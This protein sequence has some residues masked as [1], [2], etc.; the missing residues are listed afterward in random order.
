MLSD[1][2]G[3]AIAFITII[4]L[5]SVLVTSMTQLTQAV[6]RLRARNLMK[7]V[8]AVIIKAQTKPDKE[9]TREE[10]KEAKIKPHRY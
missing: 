1:V 2:L 9:P 10:I 4:L 7:C 6:F 8:T 3:I 5:L